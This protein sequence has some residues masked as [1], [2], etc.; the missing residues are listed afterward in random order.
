MVVWMTAFVALKGQSLFDKLGGNWLPWMLFKND[1]GYCYS[2]QG[3]T[4]FYSDLAPTEQKKWIAMLK[5][6]PTK[7]FLEPATYE[8]WHDLP[9]M[10]LFCV[11]DQGLPLAVQQA[12]AETLGNPTTYHASGSHSAFLSVPDQ[13]VDALK[14]ALNTGRERS[15]IT[16]N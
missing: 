1:D 9:C 5:P 6:H 8:P 7:S 16:I 2:S 15:G 10:Y 13:V 11:E 3:E 12:F 4:V 14:V